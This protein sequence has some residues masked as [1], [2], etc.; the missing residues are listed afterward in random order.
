[1]LNS[2]IQWKEK[3]TICTLE[4]CDG[5]LS[6]TDKVVR[7]SRSYMWESKSIRDYDRIRVLLTEVLLRLRR[8]DEISWRLLYSS[9]GGHF[10][11]GR[12]SLR[13]LSKE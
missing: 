6:A 5:K 12:Y 1:M 2:S 4:I 11:Q 10:S 8:G 9:Q 13:M 7:A 3:D